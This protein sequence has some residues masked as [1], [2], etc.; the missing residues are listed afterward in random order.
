M[1]SHLIHTLIELGILTM[2]DPTI[3]VN[4]EMVKGT[5]VS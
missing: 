3:R 4:R 5:K 1:M 2:V